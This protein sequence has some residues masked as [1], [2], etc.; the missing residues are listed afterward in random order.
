MYNSV[1]LIGRLTQDPEVQELEGNKKV[2]HINLAVQ[3]TYKNQD[4]IYETDFIRCSLWDGI[5]E[6]AKEYT[7]KGDLVAVRGQLKT[8]SY[9]AEDETKKYT[10]EVIIEKLVFLSTKKEEINNE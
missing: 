8:S 9:I 5:A 6:R 3:R 7:H 4:G 1:Y 2:S 10:T